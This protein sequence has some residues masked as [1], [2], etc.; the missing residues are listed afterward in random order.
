MKQPRRVHSPAKG[1]QTCQVSY[2]AGGSSSC[3]SRSC[4]AS[5]TER[6]SSRSWLPGSSSSCWCSLG[7]RTRPRTPRRPQA[8][9]PRLSQRLV[10]WSARL[11]TPRHKPSPGTLARQPRARAPQVRAP[12]SRGRPTQARVRPPVLRAPRSSRPPGRRRSPR[13]SRRERSVRPRPARRRPPQRRARRRSGRRLVPG[14]F[15]RRIRRPGGS[16]WQRSPPRLPRA[17]DR[18]LTPGRRARSFPPSR[19]RRPD[20]PPS[21]RKRP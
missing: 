2:P 9:R 19:R 21:G 16:R 18:S 11:L 17:F 12:A 13:R 7:R 8:R 3:R 20:R 4:V 6:C 1:G 15:T 14:R 5:L 10:Q